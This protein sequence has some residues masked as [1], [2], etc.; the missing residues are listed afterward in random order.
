MAFSPPAP[1]EMCALCILAHHWQLSICKEQDKKNNPYSLI[2]F[3]IYFLALYFHHPSSSRVW[4]SFDLNKKIDSEQRRQFIEF[5]RKYRTQ[6]PTDC[7]S[8][9]LKIWTED[10]YIPKKATAISRTITNVT[11]HVGARDV[12]ILITEFL[13]RDASDKLNTIYF[14]LY[15][16]RFSFPSL[17]TYFLPSLPLPLSRSRPGSDANKQNLSIVTPWTWTKF[18]NF[19]LL[20]SAYS[21]HNVNSEIIDDNFS[22][23]CPLPSHITSA[24][25][26]M[27]LKTIS[28]CCWGNKYALEFSTQFPFR[29]THTCMKWLTFIVVCKFILHIS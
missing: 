26:S 15:F 3:S 28:C 23:R 18:Y 8:R 10:P 1:R 11:R 2:C 12:A 14:E 25:A 19:W 7:D 9:C 13:S 20:F 27:G 6:L 21:I 29:V 16:A 17:P 24:W 22:P 4:L 5:K